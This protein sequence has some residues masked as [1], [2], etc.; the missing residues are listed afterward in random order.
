ME[1]AEATLHGRH[2]IEEYDALLPGLY[3]AD[4]ELYASLIN[5]KMN[6]TILFK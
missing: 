4:V 5:V 6:K 1:I 3:E 2:S